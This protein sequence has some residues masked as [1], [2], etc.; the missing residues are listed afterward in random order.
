MLMGTR[1]FHSRFRIWSIRRR[2]NV[3]LIHI[4]RKHHEEC[5]SEEPY[6]AR[7]VVHYCV[8]AVQADDANGIQ[9]PKN[10]VAATLRY[11]EQVQVLCQVEE[12][13]A[14]TGVFR[15]IACRQLAFGLGQSNGPR[16]VSALPAIR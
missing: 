9:P 16:L 5:L 3:H 8:E 2:G 13:E 7:N 12:A 14:H 6:K 4:S 1:Y 15:M 10:I 11:D